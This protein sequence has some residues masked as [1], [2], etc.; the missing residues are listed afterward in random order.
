[1][2][3]NK[4]IADVKITGNNLKGVINP[5]VDV[6]FNSMAGIKSKWDELS[7]SYKLSAEEFSTTLHL[8]DNTTIFHIGAD[9]GEEL[10]INIGDTSSTAL[11]LDSVNVLTR[12][13]ASN[14][15]GLIDTK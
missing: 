10:L 8:S 15:I 4:N 14:S 6:E 5:N 1:M 2:H 7:K 12:E 3:N 11:G 13:T 9:K